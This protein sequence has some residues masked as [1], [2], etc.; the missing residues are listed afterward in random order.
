MSS[1]DDVGNSMLLQFVPSSPC[2]F[3]WLRQLQDSTPQAFRFEV[4]PIDR[5]ARGRRNHEIR[6]DSLPHGEGDHRR[7]IGNWG[8]AVC[9]HRGDVLPELG[10][11][12]HRDVGIEQSIHRLWT[13]WLQLAADRWSSGLIQSDLPVKVRRYKPNPITHGTTQQPRLARAESRQEFRR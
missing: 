6:S 11:Y 5:E 1:D 13:D 10:A 12:Y 9:R 2:R 7:R 8:A 3:E 4:H